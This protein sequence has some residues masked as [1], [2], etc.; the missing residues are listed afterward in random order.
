MRHKLIHIIAIDPIKIVLLFATLI[1]GNGVRA[2]SN[3]D[4]TNLG[5]IINS[6][7]IEYTP[8]ISA[9]GNTMIYQSNKEGNYE[10]FLPIVI[11]VEFGHPQ[12]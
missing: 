5:G 8:S 4:M 9:D 11:Q 12:K 2:Q 1:C 7:Q 3:P 10:L 6:D